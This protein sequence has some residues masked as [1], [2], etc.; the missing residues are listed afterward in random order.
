MASSQKLGKWGTTALVL[1]N[2]IGSGIFLLPASLALYGGISLLGWL[3]SSLGA[4]VMALIFSRLSKRMPQSGGPYVFSRFGFGD[5]AGFLVAWGYWISICTT[6]AA[7]TVAFLGYLSVFFP[8]LGGNVLLSVITGLGCVW[9]LTWINTRGVQTAGYVQVITTILKITPLI[10]VAIVGLFYID[11]DHFKIFNLSDR[12]TI[13]AITETATLTLFAYLGIE[14]ATIPADNISNARQTIPKA[15]YL[16]TA[17]A[18]LIY[19]LGSFSVMGVI[20]AE[21]LRH[22]EAPF[23]DAAAIIWGDKARYMVA[24]GALIATFGALNGWILIQGQIP[25]AAAK[26]Q[27]FPSLFKQKNGRGSPVWGIL[28]SSIIISILIVLNYSR[29]LIGAFEFMILLSTLFVLVPYLFSS[30]TYILIALGTDQKWHWV[31]GVLAFGF[32]I[33]AVVGSG[34]EVVFWGFV[35]LMMG[36]PLYVFVTLKNRTSS[37]DKKR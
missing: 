6:N 21:A 26:D 12:S 15:T 27:L 35:V 20:P 1:G 19:V 11:M 33:W 36:L 34:K 9:T 30:A 24:F 10:L 2:M 7:I 25:M 18:I 23:A 14:S 37:Q 13:Q 8:I 4:L 28:I 5:F 32:S 16:G 22:S 3:M 17:L 31:W 29:G